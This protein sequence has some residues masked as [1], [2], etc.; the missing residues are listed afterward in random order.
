MKNINTELIGKILSIIGLLIAL[1]VLIYCTFLA[2]IL[3]GI[4]TVGLL[5]AIFGVILITINNDSE[6]II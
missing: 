2:H 1:T 6:R 5:L 3:A 4:F